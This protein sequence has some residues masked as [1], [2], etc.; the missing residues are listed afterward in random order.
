MKNKVFLLALLLTISF[1]WIACE[2]DSPDTVHSTSELIGK[3]TWVTEEGSDKDATYDVIISLDSSD[4]NTIKISNFQ[5]QG[6]TISA[7][8]SGSSFTFEGVLNGYLEVTNGQGTIIN[9]WQN[10]KLSYMVS[11]G[12]NPEKIVATLSRGND[13]AKKK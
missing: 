5:N 11:D 6:E 4:N 3:W 12:N 13:I 1:C 2:E 7:K 10:I 9:N 8:I